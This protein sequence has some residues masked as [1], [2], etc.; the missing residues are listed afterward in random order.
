M[1]HSRTGRG[2]GRAIDAKPR[3]AR[4][5]DRLRQSDVHGHGGCGATPAVADSEGSYAPICDTKDGYHYDHHSNLCEKDALV[6]TNGTMTVVYVGTCSAGQYS[7]V[8]AEA[9]LTE[10]ELA[11]IAK[12]WLHAPVTGGTVDVRSGDGSVHS[13]Q[14]REH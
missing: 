7:A 13:H 3:E 6:E 9:A 2:R 14:G 4:A 11:D 8:E 12:R 1:A 10:E 5:P